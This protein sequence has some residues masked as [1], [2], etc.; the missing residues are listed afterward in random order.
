[1]AAIEKLRDEL[2]A[3]LSAKSVNAVLTSAGAIF[4]L[5]LRRRLVSGNPAAEAER[6][7]MG[8][9]ELKSRNRRNSAET[10]FSRYGRMKFWTPPRS[11]GSSSRPTLDSIGR[12]F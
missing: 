9:A 12:F 4:K 1:M 7:F 10:A 8:A 3:T 6:A 5:A 11:A 2:R